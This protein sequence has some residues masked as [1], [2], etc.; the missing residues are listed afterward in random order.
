[1]KKKINIVEIN[2]NILI[3]IVVKEVLLFLLV[4]VKNGGHM[5]LK[6]NMQ[7]LENI[8]RN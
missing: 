7:N 3:S 5:N 6:K 8:L 4:I 1:M 2:L